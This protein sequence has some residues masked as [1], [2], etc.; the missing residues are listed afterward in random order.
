MSIN[1]LAN[2]TADLTNAYVY[3]FM[4]R[5]PA[6]GAAIGSVAPTFVST[7]VGSQ[8]ITINYTCTFA[9]TTVTAAWVVAPCGAVTGLR[10]RPAYNDQL[11]VTTDGLYPI[12]AP[13]L[14]VGVTVLAPLGAPC[15]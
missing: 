8:P 13:A 6:T 4:G 2:S 15:I 9:P 7:T 10:F 3:D 11:N 12:G 5:N 1:H 14:M